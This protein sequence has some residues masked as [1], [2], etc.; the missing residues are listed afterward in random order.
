[1]KKY[2]ELTKNLVTLILGNFGSKLM[3]FFLIPLYT[4]VLSTEEYGVYDLIQATVSLCIPILTLSIFDGTTRFL[5]DKKSNNNDVLNIA[6][7]RSLISFVII[8]ILIV[9][10]LFLVNVL[11]DSLGTI[12]SDETG[13]VFILKNY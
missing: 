12:N 6:I 4:S 10:G 3:G 1:M 2:R 7:K 13:F 11:G 5:L 9:I 8:V